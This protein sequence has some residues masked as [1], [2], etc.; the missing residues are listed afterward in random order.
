MPTVPE[1]TYYARHL[2]LPG[3]TDATQEKL[4]NS[5][6]LI[7]GVGGLGCPAALYLAGAG[8]GTI[9]LCDADIVSAT[10]LHRQILFD[11]TCI[12][13]NK[14][15]AAAHKLQVMNPHIKIQKLPDLAG[16]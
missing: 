5:R 16:C 11:S 8:V 4:R 9:G 15:D 3:F 10:N 2:K 14:V 12:G 6:V 7:I 1:S 13:D